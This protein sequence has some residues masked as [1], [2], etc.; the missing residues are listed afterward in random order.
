MRWTAE[1][2]E[3]LIRLALEGRSASF[4]AAALGAAS[5]NAVIGKANRIGVK[6]N[7]DG[8]AS[9]P[10]ETSARAYRALLAAVPRS[11]PVHGMQNFGPALSRDPRTIPGSQPGDRQA[12]KAAWT[13]AEAEVGEMRRVRFEEIRGSACRWP[14]GDP[15]S[16]DFAYCG[17][18]PAEGRSYCAGH[19]RMAYRRPEAGARQS[20]HERRWPRAPASR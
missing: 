11:S 4:I 16:G 7:G 18:K 2:I 13:F 5:R 3:N 6:L 20:P 17:L 14:L 9:V 15:R 12:R 10:A 8:R 19:C 1:A